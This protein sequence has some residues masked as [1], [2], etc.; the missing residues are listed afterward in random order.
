MSEDKKIMNKKMECFSCRINNSLH[1]S[2]PKFYRKVIDL[3]NYTGFCH[4]SQNPE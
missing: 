4:C 2:V 1:I 3:I